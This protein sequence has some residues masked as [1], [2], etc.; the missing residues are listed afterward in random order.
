MQAGIHDKFVE[1]ISEA[2]SH[3]KLGDAFEEGVTRTLM[4]SAPSPPAPHW[5]S[6]TLCEGHCPPTPER[7]SSHSA[8]SSLPVAVEPVKEIF[9][10]R[11]LLHSTLPTSGEFWWLED[12]TLKTPG[13]MDA[14][15]ESYKK[16]T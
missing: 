4:P 15:W 11:S 13:G 9:W 14:C 7:A 6:Q 3:L 2:V 5:P 1:A 16:N 10:T 8:R 12:I